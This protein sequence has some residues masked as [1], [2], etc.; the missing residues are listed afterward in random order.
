MNGRVAD[1]EPSWSKG[2]TPKLCSFCSDLH[3]GIFLLAAS[4]A[5]TLDWEKEVHSHLPILRKM[6]LSKMFYNR[7]SIAPISS[8]PWACLL[9]CENRQKQINLCSTILR[10]PSRI[11]S[12]KWNF[13]LVFA[14]KSPKCFAQAC[15]YLC[16]HTSVISVTFCNSDWGV[17]GGR[18]RFAPIHHYLASHQL[19][20]QIPP[21]EP[22]PNTK[23]HH[24]N[25][26][27]QNMQGCQGDRPWGW[28]G[29]T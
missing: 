25:L 15:K 2:S 23:Y 5:T 3:S 16:T 17:V 27:Q 24:Q 10:P 9:V 21:W 8:A 18:R 26:C 11:I 13:P 4:W 19:R 20:H 12:M 7:T 28:G 14:H 6:E 1:F 29:H 22:V